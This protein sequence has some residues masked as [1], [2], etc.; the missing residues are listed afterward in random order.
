MEQYALKSE[1]ERSLKALG[2]DKDDLFV[3]FVNKLFQPIS[4]NG[5]SSAALARPDLK[6]FVEI[7][8]RINDLLEQEPSLDSDKYKMMTTELLRSIIVST[9]ADDS[10]EA[11]LKY[12]LA[13]TADKTMTDLIYVKDHFLVVFGNLLFGRADLI[14]QPH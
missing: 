2:Y 5:G 9:F 13:D 6:D 12:H 10:I 14:G 4:L 3:R 7:Q 1:L 8:G 11:G